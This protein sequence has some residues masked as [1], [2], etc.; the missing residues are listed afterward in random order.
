MKTKGTCK[1]LMKKFSRQVYWA[2]KTPHIRYFRLI[3]STINRGAHYTDVY[4][5]H[6]LF[7]ELKLTNYR[8]IPEN[9]KASTFIRLAL[10]QLSRYL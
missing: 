7:D 2:E 10:V 8:Q 1:I 3:G 6:K 4:L 5:L 9:K